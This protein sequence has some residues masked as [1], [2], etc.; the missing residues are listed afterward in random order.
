MVTLGRDW[1]NFYTWSE[2]RV[3][4]ILDTF[5]VARIPNTNRKE[6]RDPTARSD[7]L[8]DRLQGILLV[9]NCVK[10][11]LDRSTG[12][13]YDLLRDIGRVVVEKRS[14]AERA[15]VIVMLGGRDGEDLLVSSDV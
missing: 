9:T 15:E 10:D 3:R 12:V 13:S 11:E 4:G 7:Y 14:S 6:E 1:N 8:G 5:H 2:R